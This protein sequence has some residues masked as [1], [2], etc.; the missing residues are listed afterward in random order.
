MS[1]DYE[2]NEIVRVFPLWSIYFR[3]TA[4]LDLP[5][6]DSCLQVL[7]VCLQTFAE[8]SVATLDFEEH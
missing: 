8:I 4:S 1:S 6:S 7:E 3:M 2:T 5:S